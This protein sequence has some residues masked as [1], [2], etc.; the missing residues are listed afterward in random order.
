[1]IRE[2]LKTFG[3][4]NFNIKPYNKKGELVEGIEVGICPEVG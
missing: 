2:E 4:F 1:M 3:L